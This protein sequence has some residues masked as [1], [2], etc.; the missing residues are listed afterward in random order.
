DLVTGVQTCALPISTAQTGSAPAFGDGHI[1]DGGSH[2][3]GR[4]RRLRN[5]ATNGTQLKNRTCGIDLSGNDLGDGS[6]HASVLEWGRLRKGGDKRRG[7]AA[8]VD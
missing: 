1:Q 6:I 5:S 7:M 4:G 3:I 2:R 8:A